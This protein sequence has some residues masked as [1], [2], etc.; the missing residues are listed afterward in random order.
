MFDRVT[1]QAVSQLF[2]DVWDWFEAVLINEKATISQT[3]YLTLRSQFGRNTPAH[4]IKFAEFSIAAVFR[5]VFDNNRPIF[6]EGFYY[7]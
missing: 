2:Y 6:S 1:E 3:F 4:R 5:P 7:V